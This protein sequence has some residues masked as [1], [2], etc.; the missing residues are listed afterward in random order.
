M[1]GQRPGQP[2]NH[3]ESETQQEKK[4]K[5]CHIL[6]KSLTQQKHKKAGN[7]LTSILTN[8]QK[9]IITEHLKYIR[10]FIKQLDRGLK[11]QKHYSQ[12]FHSKHTL[13]DLQSA[14][15]ILASLT[16]WSVVRL[17]MRTVIICRGMCWTRLARA[18]E[19][20]NEGSAIE[21]HLVKTCTAPLTETVRSSFLCP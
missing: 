1:M 2:V 21:L 9:H 17:L 20:S 3:S 14:C 6:N 19:G 15:V 12:A 18:I 10:P 5:V 8:P 11:T 4:V 16:F 13:S 7:I